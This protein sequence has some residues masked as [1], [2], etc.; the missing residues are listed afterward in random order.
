[1]ASAFKEPIEIVGYRLRTP[2]VVYIFGSANKAADF[3]KADVKS[4]LQVAR[5]ERKTAVG[6]AFFQRSSIAGQV[7]ESQAAR[8]TYLVASIVA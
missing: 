6:W 2:S 1:M 4:I 8:R 3:T 7:V 5:G